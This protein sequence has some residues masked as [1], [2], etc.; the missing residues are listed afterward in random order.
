MSLLARCWGAALAWFVLVFVGVVGCSR[1]P[2]SA[3]P[4]T[5]E[6]KA[7]IKTEDQKVFEAERA[8]R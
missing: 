3:P 4:M 2:P 6:M 5:E 8:Q 7:A 1:T